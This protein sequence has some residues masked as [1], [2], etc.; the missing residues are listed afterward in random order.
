[1]LCCNPPHAHSVAHIKDTLIVIG[2]EVDIFI[3]VCLLDCNFVQKKNRLIE[4]ETYCQ[5]QLG[6]FRI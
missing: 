6:L 5:F 1:M 3:D 2:C 4:K